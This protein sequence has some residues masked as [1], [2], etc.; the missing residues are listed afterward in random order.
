VKR[1]GQPPPPCSCSDN[2]A[3]HVAD[4]LRAQVL[5]DF[6]NQPDNQPDGI[7]E[8]IGGDAAGH[9]AVGAIRA[10]FGLRSPMPSAA[11]DPPAAFFLGIAAAA[12]V[13]GSMRSSMVQSRMS[14]NAIRIFKLS[15]SGRS[16]TKR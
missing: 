5:F 16:V 11:A 2:T 12:S 4:L 6:T 15:R 1:L 10:R 7:C 9:R 13:T 3:N 14:S 8:H